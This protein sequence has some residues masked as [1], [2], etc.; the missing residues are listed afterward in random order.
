MNSDNKMQFHSI[1]NIISR[2][3]S[4]CFHHLASIAHVLTLSLLKIKQ[5]C[6][7]SPDTLC[8]YEKGE[9]LNELSVELPERV[10]LSKAR[11]SYLPADDSCIVLSDFSVWEVLWIQ[12]QMPPLLW[13]SCL[14]TKSTWS[15]I[16]SQH[17]ALHMR[18]PLSHSSYLFFFFLSASFPF[19]WSYF[20]VD[21]TYGQCIYIDKM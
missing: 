18:Q 8:L 2:L 13:Y 12:S 5:T 16:W 17:A 14:D 10:E 21:K 11:W 3:F 19:L 20:S 6:P 1:Q 4:N 15:S 9:S 7:C